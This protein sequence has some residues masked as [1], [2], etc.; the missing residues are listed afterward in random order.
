[1]SR[2]RPREEIM[3]HQNSVINGDNA[4][5][6]RENSPISAVSICACQKSRINEK[7]KIIP[8]AIVPCENV[9]F[10]TKY[11]VAKCHK[12]PQSLDFMSFARN[13]FTSLI[14]FNHNI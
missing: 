3:F 10:D 8:H 14:S 13:L 12:L 7:R 11:R 1:M 6:S 4:S 2:K 9:L 5:C